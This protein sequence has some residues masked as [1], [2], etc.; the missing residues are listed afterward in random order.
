MWTVCLGILVLFLAYQSVKAGNARG[1]I[2]YKKNLDEVCVTVDG[3]KLT[4]R[5]LAFY[6]AYE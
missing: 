6:V 4:F 5:D 2:D 1:K 3:K